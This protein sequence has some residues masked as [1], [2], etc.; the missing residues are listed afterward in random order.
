[1]ADIHRKPR[2]ALTPA[3]AAGIDEA[4]IRRLVHAF[5][6][7]ARRDPV[8]GPIFE[9]AVAGAWDAHL[10]KLCDFW[11]SVLLMSGRFSGAPMAAHVRRPDIEDARRG[12]AVHRQGRDDRREPPLRP[13]GGPR[14]A[15]VPADVVVFMRGRRLG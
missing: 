8:L 14:T 6:G 9:D 5:Y 12:P 10:A 13:G 2:A 11:S 4:M 7:E 3:E 1:M 15:A